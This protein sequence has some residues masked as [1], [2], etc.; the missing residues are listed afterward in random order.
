[1]QTEKKSISKVFLI[2]LG[3]VVALLVGVGGW[4][5]GTKIFENEE[6]VAKAKNTSLKVNEG[7]DYVY[8]A[9]FVKVEYLNRQEE[10]SNG[11]LSN[12][13]NIKL[14]Y[15]NLRT[16]DAKKVNEEIKGIY[17]DLETDIEES[18]LCNG[19]EMCASYSLGY[20]M[21]SNDKTL[22][23]VIIKLVGATD[24]PEPSYWVY[25]FDLTTGKLLTI[26]SILHQKNITKESFLEKVKKKMEQFALDNNTDSCNYFGNL[27]KSYISLEKGIQTS[28]FPVEEGN[29]SIA[30][31]LGED[32]N[33]H[34]IATLYMDCG[35]GM[36]VENFPL[37]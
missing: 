5:L 22:S 30:Y 18:L 33:I 16:E 9:D 19:N 20:K 35:R 14:P 26:D 37:D 2:L 15:I 13:E 31:Y 6:G 25:N 8:D 10:F 36:I 23:I 29:D 1:M 12:N 28:A 3:V 21:Y 24:I 11:F 27:Q 17:T 34:L 4:F 7:K 32:G